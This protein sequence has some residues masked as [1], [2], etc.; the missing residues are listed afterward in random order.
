MTGEK[1]VHIKSILNS[2][3]NP[4][5]PAIGI[6]IFLFVN[7][8]ILPKPILKAIELTGSMTTPLSMLLI[9]SQLTRANLLDIIKDKSIY[10]VSFSRL[11]LVPSLLILTVN[12]LKLPPIVGGVTVMLSGMP[13]AANTAIFARLYMEDKDSVFASK[14]VVA[15]TLLSMLTIPILISV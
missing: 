6:G 3:K 8:I 11:I 5:I 14:C 4:A 12:I 7:N 13:A 2:L 1:G 10:S 15:T 9:G